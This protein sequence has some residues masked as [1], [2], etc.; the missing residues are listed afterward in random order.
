MFDLQK[1]PARHS[2]IKLLNEINTKSPP[3]IFETG[4]F[5]DRQFSDMAC[6]HLLETGGLSQNQMISAHFYSVELQLSC[7]AL[8]LLQQKRVV[9]IFVTEVALIDS[10]VFQTQYLLPET[11]LA[12]CPKQP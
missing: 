12:Q 4:I 2:F 5:V 8:K 9:N 3:R 11:L 7:S 10:S 1:L 6:Y